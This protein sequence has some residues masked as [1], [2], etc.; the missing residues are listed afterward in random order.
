LLLAC[1]KEFICDIIINVFIWHGNWKDL[2]DT[3]IEHMQLKIKHMEICQKFPIAIPER[4]VDVNELPSEILCNKYNK[5][6]HRLFS[7]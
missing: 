5:V 7:N 1:L 2:M 6:E 4:K 3:Y